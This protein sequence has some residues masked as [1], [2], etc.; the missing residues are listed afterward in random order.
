LGVLLAQQ[1]RLL[2]LERVLQQLL[3]VRCCRRNLRLNLRLRLRPA[4]SCSF[5][6]GVQRT[7]S[8][9]FLAA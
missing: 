5:Y 2:L 1:V 8:E 3:L 9:T 7:L 6:A 4:N